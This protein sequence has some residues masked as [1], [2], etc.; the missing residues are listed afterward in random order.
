MTNEDMDEMLRAIDEA[1]GADESD[2]DVAAT[3]RRVPPAKA[4]AQVYSVRVPS[5]RLQ[6]LR[7]LSE[8]EGIPTSALVR[9]LVVEGIERRLG[10]LG[11]V[12]ELAERVVRLESD[13]NELRKAYKARDDEL[14]ERGA[15]NA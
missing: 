4:P 2:E 14:R 1:E 6:Q 10:R 11:E 13:M 12:E 5:N 7:G 9:N 3:Y 15:H 8:L